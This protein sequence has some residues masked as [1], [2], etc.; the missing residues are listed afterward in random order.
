[1]TEHD[2]RLDQMIKK[3]SRTREMERQSDDRALSLLSLI[4]PALNTCSLSEIALILDRARFIIEE[5][6]GWSLLKGESEN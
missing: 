1:M 5:A 3:L 6:H 2:G 4:L